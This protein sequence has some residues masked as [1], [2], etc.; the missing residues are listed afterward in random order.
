[1]A[2]ILKEHQMQ[3]SGDAIRFVAFNVDD[4]QQKAQAYLTQI[5]L[6]A[7]EIIAAA[8]SDFEIE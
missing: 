6:Q 2:T 7:T 5:R 1:M 4:V 3:L 8:E